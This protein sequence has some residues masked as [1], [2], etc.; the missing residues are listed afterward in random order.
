MDALLRDPRLWRPGD[1]RQCDQAAVGT[2]FANLDALLPGGGWPLGGLSEIVVAQQGI[3]GLTVIDG[4]ILAYMQAGG[5]VEGGA[6]GAALE[7]GGC[8]AAEPPPS[9]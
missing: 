4:G 6:P 1:G 3:G 7:G 8:C 5:E 2:G 9:P